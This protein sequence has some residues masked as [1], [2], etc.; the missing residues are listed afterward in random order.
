MKP[1]VF[2]A[3]VLSALPFLP[4]FG[5]S[6]PPD[7]TPRR[8]AT[9]ALVGAAGRA[10]ERVDAPSNFAAPVSL[11]FTYQGRLEINDAPANGAYDLRFSLYDDTGVL[12][13]GPI[14]HDN[15]D[16]D[17]GVFTVTLDFGS[18]FTGDARL[19]EIAVRPGGAAGDCHLG[20]GYTTMTPRQTLTATPYALGLRL[21]F[22]G[23]RLLPGDDVFSILNTTTSNSSSGIR[24]VI[25]TPAIFGFIDSAGVQGDSSQSVGAGVLGISD[26]YVGVI[27][28]SAG[29]GGRGV[30]GRTDGINSEAVWGW[31]TGADSKAVY[32]EALNPSSWAGYF[33][34]RSYFNGNVGIG[35]PT[36]AS[37]LDVV[38]TARVTGL[39]L[40]TGA[41]AGRVL[42]SDASGNGTWQALPTAGNEALYTAGSGTAPTATTAFLSPTVGVTITAGQKIH[43]TATQ[44]FGSTAVGGA[45]SLDIHIGY[46]LMPSGT[47]T[48]VGGGMWDNR[49]PQNTRWPFTVSAVITGLPAGSYLVGMAGDDDGNGNWNNME[50][51]YVSVIVLN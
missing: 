20:G 10:P 6:A 36:P 19:L 25:G 41:A 46:R 37:K 29:E 49:V 48:L 35:T 28:Y 47:L 27:G 11:G 44:T 18:Q 23:S 30:F 31:A 40:P 7:N 3:C 9:G 43:V 13:A 16:V 5:Q 26:E 4:A 14:C 21:P 8:T 38:G 50:W 24:G 33:D 51:G 42:T 12:V 32:G 1:T 17:Q 15:V 34:G 22:T 2:T 45:A 39:Q